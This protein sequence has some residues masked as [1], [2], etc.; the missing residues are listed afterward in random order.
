MI[1]D[2]AIVST[3]DNPT[4]KDF[5][6]VVKPVWINHIKIKPILVNIGD[7]DEVIDN[8]DHI[9]Y[10]IKK[11]E[12]IDTG[13]QSQVSRMWVTKFF[14]EKVCLISDIDM[15]PMSEKYFKENV[16]DVDDDSM[17]IYSADAYNPYIDRYPMCYI[18]AKGK[19]FDE[20]LQLSRYDNFESFCRSLIK[21]GQGWD[22][23]ELFFGE[24]VNKFKNQDQIIKLNRGWSN[25]RADWR[26]DRIHWQHNYKIENYIDS[27]LLRPYSNYKEIIDK[28]IEDLVK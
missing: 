9:I 4:Y 24:Y 16:I 18:S 10:N 3:N 8:Y 1:I 22:T 15:L 6:E 17:V 28:L 5:W 19:T 20:I 11:I 25:G 14:E 13:F 27:H 21:R 23:D 12:G 2:Y 26:I 7:N